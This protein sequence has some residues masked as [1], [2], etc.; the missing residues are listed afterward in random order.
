MSTTINTLLKCSV[1]PNAIISGFALK[2]TKNIPIYIVDY[3][4]TFE[5]N[6]RAQTAHF[7]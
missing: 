3:E 4:I 5:W 1:P 2:S 7:S 6:L